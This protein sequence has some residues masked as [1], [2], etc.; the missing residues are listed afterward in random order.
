[1]EIICTEAAPKNDGIDYSE[2]GTGF[3]YDDED[4]PEE[5]EEQ[6]PPEE[7]EVDPREVYKLLG[8]TVK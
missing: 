1:M 2:G 8:G 3:H 6:T 4:E 5:I 7:V